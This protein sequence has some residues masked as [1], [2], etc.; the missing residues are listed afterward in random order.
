MDNSGQLEQALWK[1]SD[2]SSFLKIS[3]PRLPG[4]QFQH[5]Y[6]SNRET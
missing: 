6:S 2:M 3:A 5:N 1:S 4:M